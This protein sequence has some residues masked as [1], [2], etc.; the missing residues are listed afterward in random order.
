VLLDFLE[1]SLAPKLE[2]TP[3]VLGNL[4]F[5]WAFLS[6]SSTFPVTDRDSLP[7]M[8]VLGNMVYKPGNYLCTYLIG[9]S[10]YLMQYCSNRIF[11]IYV[12]HLC[13]F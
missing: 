6:V 13:A 2:N 12:F 4:C 3:M 8:W 7:F 9:A 10:L 1:V 5:V 11:L